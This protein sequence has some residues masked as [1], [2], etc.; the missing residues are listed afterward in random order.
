M[1]YDDKL[2]DTEFNKSIGIVLRQKRIEKNMSLKD[3]SKKINNKVSRQTLDKYETGNSKIRHN[4][5][6]DLCN[7]YNTK[8]EDL[9]DEIIVNYIK[10]K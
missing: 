2:V 8:P 10:H 7:V 4:I 3:L 5:F 6:I 9:L 1:I